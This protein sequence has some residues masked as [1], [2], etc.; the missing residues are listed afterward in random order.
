MIHFKYKGLCRGLAIDIFVKNSPEIL[1]QVI[2][3]DGTC[4]CQL[5]LS[6]RM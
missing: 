4:M 2:E 3:V 1:E 5:F 6:V